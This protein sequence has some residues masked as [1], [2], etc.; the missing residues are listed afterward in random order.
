L[1]ARPI[2]QKTGFPVFDWEIYPS[3][4]WNYGLVIDPGRP[5]SFV[6]VVRHPIGKVPFAQKGEPVIRK[7]DG[8]DPAKLS[9]AMFKADVSVVLPHPAE[10]DLLPAKTASTDGRPAANARNQWVAFDRVTWPHDEPVVLRVKGRLLPQ[11]KMRMGKNPQVSRPVPAM[12]EVPPSS[13]V[14]AAGETVDIE[15]VP[16]GCARLRVTEFPWLWPVTR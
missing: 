6:T 3:T 5:E 12:A 11:W 15:L 4:P 14:E 2:R 13:P 9:S 10:G 8:M 7:I 1:A 16:F